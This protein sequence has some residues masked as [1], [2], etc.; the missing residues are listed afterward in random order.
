MSDNQVSNDIVRD[1]RQYASY[2]TAAGS[3][4]AAMNVKA[5]E[6]KEAVLNLDELSAREIDAYVNSGDLTAEQVYAHESAAEHPRKTVLKKYAPA[7]EA[8][9]TEE[10]APEEDAETK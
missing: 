10:E 8:E 5:T 3:S 2:E 9:E 6:K 1:V 7:E 4:D